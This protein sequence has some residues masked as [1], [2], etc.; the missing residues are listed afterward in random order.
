MET[1]EPIAQTIQCDCDFC[2]QLTEHVFYDIAPAPDG[3]DESWPV[4]E[5]TLCGELVC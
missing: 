5:C 4:W 2:E 3:R 1:K